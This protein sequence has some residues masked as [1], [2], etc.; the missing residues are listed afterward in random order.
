MK[1]GSFRAVRLVVFLFLMLSVTG[2]SA[3]GDENTIDYLSV[4][5]DDFSGET[6]HQWQYGGKVYNYEFDWSLDASKF[7]STV[8]GEQFPKLT[9]V[10]AWPMALYGLNRNNLDILSLGIWG[11]FDR[12]GY[13]W[14]DVYPSVPGSGQNGEDPEP[15]E[16][17]IPGRVQYLDMWVWGS[18]LN[19]YMEAYFRDY[20]GVVHTLHLG[21]LGYQGWKNLKIKIP[22]SIPQSKRVLPRYAGLTFVKFRIWT[23]PGE[24]VDNFYVYF[25]QMKVLT[26]TFESLFDGDD[27]ND[28]DNVQRIWAQN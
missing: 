20:Q 7:A 5:L 22:T 6:T 15:F 24:R 23:T 13:N 10:E 9:R 21:N 8:K 2:F 14:I 12:R 4:V 27:L 1:Q 26:D 3:F 17:P 16:I 19:Y 28:P 18:N 25:N 11:E